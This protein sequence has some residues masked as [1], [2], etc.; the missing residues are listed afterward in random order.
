[1]LVL[2]SLVLATILAGLSIRSFWIDDWISYRVLD[3]VRQRWTM[4]D[5]SSG[6]GTIYVSYS[7]FVFSSPHAAEAYAQGK[8]DTPGLFHTMK[9]AR[10][11]ELDAFKDSF[12]HRMN[13]ALIFER[14]GYNN[15]YEG[16]HVSL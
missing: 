14:G 5:I 3:A 4:Y 12:L 6:F 11:D 9:P 10:K 13:F 1:M 16:D 7:P 2:V 8:L 15:P